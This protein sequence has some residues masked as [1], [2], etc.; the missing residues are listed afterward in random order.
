MTTFRKSALIVATCL[1]LAACGEGGPSDQDVKNA[2]KQQASQLASL[3]DPTSSN[4]QMS[5]DMQQKLNSIQI[6]IGTKTK[7]SDGTYAVVV[8]VNGQT[9]IL[10]FVKG[11]DGWDILPNS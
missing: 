7:Q 10:K 3:F 8:T 6:N 9:S 2:V 11:S 1:A 5:P 4:G